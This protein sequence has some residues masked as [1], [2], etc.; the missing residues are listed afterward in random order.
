[1]SSEQG[2]GPPAEGRGGPVRHGSRGGDGQPPVEVSF[3]YPVSDV[4]DPET[5]ASDRGPVY[6]YRYSGT[7]ELEGVVNWWLF[8][9]ILGLAAWG[10]FYTLFYWGGPG[11]GLDYSVPV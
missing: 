5:L 7:R 2:A 10:V 4:Y 11:P 9:V 6:T 3:P 8:A 1:M